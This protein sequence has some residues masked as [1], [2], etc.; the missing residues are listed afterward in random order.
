M[1]IKK[2]ELSNKEKK[3]VNKKIETTIKKRI[4]NKN[5]IWRTKKINKKKEESGG[6]YRSKK[7]EGNI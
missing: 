2:E 3:S 7:K 4:W 1:K 5:V 6:T